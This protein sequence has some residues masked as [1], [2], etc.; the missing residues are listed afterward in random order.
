MDLSTIGSFAEVLAAVG[1]IGSL[2]F[3]A[4]QV[5]KNTQ[6]LRSQVLEMHFDRVALNY[7]RALDPDVAD[8]IEKGRRNYETLSASE[9]IIFNA[10]ASEYV[11]NTDHLMLFKQEGLI[12][13]AAATMID[14]RIEW[15]FKHNG[16]RAWWKDEDRH[17]SPDQFERMFDEQIKLKWPERSEPAKIEPNSHPE[18][19]A[20]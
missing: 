5:Q 19:P 3:L 14:R 13:P 20:E 8:V 12:V 15:F 4:V 2:I 16:V 9:K 7:A 10:W 6:A 1:V 17:P 11:L 18:N